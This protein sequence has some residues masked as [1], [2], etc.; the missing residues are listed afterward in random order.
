MRPDSKFLTLEELSAL[1]TDAHRPIILVN[2]K[3]ADRYGCS[4][5]GQFSSLVI[6]AI[7]TIAGKVDLKF[8]LVLING[9]NVYCLF[10]SLRLIIF[11]DY[12]TGHTQG[13]DPWTRWSARPTISKQQNKRY[14]RLR[15]LHNTRAKNKPYAKVLV[16]RLTVE[17][18]K[19]LIRLFFSQT[20]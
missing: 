1:P 17:C 3:N 19:F 5:P 4:G 16:A 8:L 6:T 13:Y 18:H 12:T 9:Q 10:I 11:L 20:Y 15:Y 7:K 2:S 14:I